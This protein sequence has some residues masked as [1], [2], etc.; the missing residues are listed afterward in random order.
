MSKNIKTNE[1]PGPPFQCPECTHKPFNARRAL[2]LHRYKFHGI[3]G[4]SASTIYARTRLTSAPAATHHKSKKAAPAMGRPRTTIFTFLQNP[5]E[6]V[7][8]IESRIESVENQIR[9]L[10][11]ELKTLRNF[12][13]A[14]DSLTG[15]QDK[16]EVAVGE[17]ATSA[18]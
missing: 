6:T 14:F 12:R 15:H 4:T 3:A 18:A 17:L 8:S 7:L 1:I 11:N 2:G 9:A 13:S 10:E 16:P 5:A